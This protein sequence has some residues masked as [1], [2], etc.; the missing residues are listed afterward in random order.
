[1][2]FGVHFLNKLISEEEYAKFGVLLMM[3]S[4]IPATPLQMVFAQQS[5][6]G[7]FAIHHRRWTTKIQVHGH[8]RVLLQLL[9]RAHE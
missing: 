3:I 2:A 6:S 4:C 9:R 8:D 7:A 5:A 1:M